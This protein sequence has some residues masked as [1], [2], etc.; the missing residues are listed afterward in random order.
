MRDIT[1]DFAFRP[2]FIPMPT[3]AE[4][5]D[6]LQ[7]FKCLAQMFS[8]WNSSRCGG[9]KPPISLS[10]GLARSKTFQRFI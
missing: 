6:L 9:N 3:L 1:L 7:P 10:T 5:L 4:Q 8:G 2:S